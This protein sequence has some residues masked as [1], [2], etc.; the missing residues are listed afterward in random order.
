[1]HSG[2]AIWRLE[3][4]PVH[5]Q[6]ADPPGGVI[7]PAGLPQIVGVDPNDPD[8]LPNQQLLDLHFEKAFGYRTGK[9]SFVLDGFNIFNSA[10]PLNTD[11]IFDYGQ[12]TSI[13]TARRFRAG[14]RYEF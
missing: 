14:V 8:Y 4:Y 9:L 6:F 12:V 7:N 11:V 1:M 13:P 5:T 10:A 3:N 2:R